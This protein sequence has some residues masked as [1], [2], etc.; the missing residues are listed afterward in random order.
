MFR[1]LETDIRE[2]KKNEKRI[3]TS[4]DKTVNNLRYKFQNRI[5]NKNNFF[6]KRTIAFFKTKIHLFLEKYF[7]HFFRIPKNIIASAFFFFFVEADTK[8]HKYASAKVSNAPLVN[9]A[10]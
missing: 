5:K 3:Q 10:G 1:F 7:F 6:I 4:V 9:L 2:Q 8:D